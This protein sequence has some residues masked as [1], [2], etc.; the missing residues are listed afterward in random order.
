MLPAKMCPMVPNPQCIQL[1]HFLLTDPGNG[2]I[3]ATIG[4][5]KKKTCI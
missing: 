5:K 4:W 2:L 3:N 1:K